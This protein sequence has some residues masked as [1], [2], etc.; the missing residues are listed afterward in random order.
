MVALASSPGKPATRDTS[1][2][3]EQTP[4]PRRRQVHI[5][6]LINDL[7]HHTKYHVDSPST[8]LT[9][10]GSLQS[11]VVDI[12]GAASSYNPERYPNHHQ[13]IQDLI[14]L[15]ERQAYYQSSYINEL[16]ATVANS[17]TLGD[18]EDPKPVNGGLEVELIEASTGK[19]DAPYIMPASHGDPSTPY[20]D[21]PAGNLLPHIIPNSTVPIDPQQVKPLQ[22]VARP[23]D[24][25]LT[26][27]VK[28]FMK[29]VDSLGTV[30]G[31]D[32]E[33]VEMDIDELGQPMVRNE[34]AGELFGGEGYYGWSKTFCERMKRR[35]DGT[36]IIEEST[37][38]DN[39]DRSS[40]P[41]KRK[42]YSSSGSSKR[43]SPSSRSISRSSRLRSRSRSPSRQRSSSYSPPP[44]VSS[45]QQPRL[46]PT[47]NIPTSLPSQLQA[48]SR[49]L[50][51]PF[52]HDLIQGFPLGPGGLPIPPPPPHYQGLWPPP[53]PPLP[54]GGGP[55][56]QG[57]SYPSFPPFIPPPPP[58]PAGP[59]RFSSAGSP[60]LPYAVTGPQGQMP[61]NA[62][63]WGPPQHGGYPAS[64]N[65]RPHNGHYPSGRDRGQR[66]SW[67]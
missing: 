14:R 25:S 17:I 49:P 20:Y 50:P 16:R 28:N 57:N 4:S 64:T 22:F 5:L 3:K 34:G 33:G 9:L 15:W 54:Q 2:V 48:S 52:P 65:Q 53:P 30:V 18:L 38:S 23:A 31:S 26:K 42:R 13:K 37:R 12:V 55:L 1:M 11:Y 61:S 67:G 35:R 51:V 62:G 45:S 8:Y 27:A 36:G 56:P 7:L 24:E 6:Y 46:V 58:P 44:V 41:R 10:S 39:L 59:G 43:S 21:L 19:Q 63:R 47:A 40:S 32:E 66:G 60:P 29:D